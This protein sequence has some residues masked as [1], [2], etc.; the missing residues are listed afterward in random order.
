M[1]WIQCSENLSPEEVVEASRA[2]LTLTAHVETG[3]SQDM[4][5]SAVTHQVV[6]RLLLGAIEVVQSDTEA[7]GAQQVVRATR[8]SLPVKGPVHSV[9]MQPPL[10]A[11][12]A[13]GRQAGAH[14]Q[15]RVL[16]EDSSH[17]WGRDIQKHTTLNGLHSWS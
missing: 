11:H 17:C 6:P 16:G 13:R 5:I 4:S 14:P 3:A 12:C 10:G 1:I 9:G 7:V 15:R 8:E 2:S